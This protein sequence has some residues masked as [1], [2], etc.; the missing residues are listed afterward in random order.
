[1]SALNILLVVGVA[2]VGAF[3]SE[4]LSSAFIN[5]RASY[6]E[7]TALLTA[8]RADVARETAHIAQQEAAG[9]AATT[10]RRSRERLERAEKS[11]SDAQAKQAKAR[12]PGFLISIVTLFLTYRVLSFMFNDT[13]VA[14]LPF[15]APGPMRALGHRMLSDA[16][17]ESLGE[18]VDYAAGAQLIYAMSA[19]VIRPL[20]QRAL[21]TLT[22][23]SMSAE[24]TLAGLL[25]GGAPT[26]YK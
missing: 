16:V 13:V 8:A 3:L 24:N 6:K 18:K 7:A 10:L 19:M 2:T 15:A 12:L 9:A 11:R 25:S 22:P 5:R 26:T 4:S 20:A 23:R 1:M 21:G 17:K 14:E